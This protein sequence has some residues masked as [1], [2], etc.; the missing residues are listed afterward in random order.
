[1]M[2]TPIILPD[3]PSE[4]FTWDEFAC[5]DILRT[6]YPLDWRCGRGVELGAEL[7]AIRAQIGPFTPTSV[8]RTWQHHESIYAAMKPPQTPP[9]ASQHLY[10]R[11]ADVACPDGMPWNDFV[12]HVLKAAQRDNGKIRMVQ[13]HRREHFAHVDC[14]VTM[15]ALKVAYL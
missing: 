1:M 14:R 3:R 13:F 5:K 11:A 6:P 15:Q 9:S 2:V 8:Y 12:G 10:G 4:H 7:E